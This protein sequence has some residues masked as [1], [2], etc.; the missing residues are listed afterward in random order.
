MKARVRIQ[1]QLESNPL[2]LCGSEI[3]EVQS[4]KY[5]G[6]MLGPSVSQS[7]SD[8]VNN[9]I[10]MAR[11]AIYEIRAVIEDSRANAIGAI[12]VGINLWEMTVIPMLYF[13]CEIWTEISTKTLKMLDS[14]NSLF[15]ANLFGVSKRGC[16]EAS[17][18]LETASLLA[19]NRILLHKLLFYHHVATLSPDSLAREIL[20]EQRK[21]SFPN[22]FVSQCETTLSEWNLTNVEC[23]SKWSWKKAIKKRLKL[24]NEQDL[25]NWGSSYKKIDTD[26]YCTNPLKLNSS[27]KTLNLKDS[28][29]LFRKN[30][31]LLQTVRLN[32]KGNKKFKSEDY[33]CPDCLALDPP[34]SHPDHQ[35]NLLLCQG[36]SDLRVGKDLGDL[37]QELRY[38]RDIIERRTRMG[39]N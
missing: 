38:Y 15:L 25:V 32:F 23:Y 28:R 20:E 3:K 1:R 39:T 34:V 21:Y 31:Y 30:S 8:T 17:L 2:R 18:F 22:S 6:C 16:P 27:Y 24:K 11:R 9:R 36:N 29:V 19:A 37:R 12:E 33:L 5:L 13:S 14:V 26:K 10:G 35:D 7:V 4:N